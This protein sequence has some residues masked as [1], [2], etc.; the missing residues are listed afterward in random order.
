MGAAVI[1]APQ[2]RKGRE[3]QH[4]STFQDGPNR[5]NR[6]NEMIPANKQQNNARRRSGLVLALVGLL[7]VTGL[8]KG[9]TTPASAQAEARSW[10]YT[11]SLNIARFGH[12][13]TRLPDGKVLVVGGLN[14]IGAPGS[15]EL[16]DPIT[17]LWSFTGNLNVPR[18][19]HTATLLED[20]KVLV[21]GGAY[22]GA[23]TAEVYDPVTGLWSLTGNLNAVRYSHTATRL[24]DGKVLIAGGGDT[25][26]LGPTNAAEVYDPATRTWSLTGNL[27]E[28]R[29]VHTAT[30]LANGEVLVAGGINDF[31][32][33]F[34]LNSAEL[35]D[36]ATKTWRYT[37]SLNTG[38]ADYA[39]VLLLNGD[40]LAAGGDYYSQNNSSEI[41]HV[42]KGTWSN[43]AGGFSLRFYPTLTLLQNGKALITGGA[44]FG[45]YGFFGLPGSTFS[46]AHL[47]NP[48]TGSWKQTAKL[49]EPRAL[50]TATLLSDGKVLVV[51][52]SHAELYDPEILDPAPKIISASV[53]GIKLF[54]T[55]EN[56]DDGAVILLNGE[57]QKTKQPAANPQT[58]LIGKKAGKNI[59][60]GDRVQVRNPDGTLSAEFIFTGS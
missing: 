33:Q 24:R 35:Y 40:V 57:E 15:A 19:E 47:Y 39:A 37:G 58:S 41:Y 50:H 38:R 52:G 29:L 30:L 44:I 34:L 32:G 17:G 56:F 46:D 54:I 28:G 10:S 18:F 12:T 4:G 45:R 31:E 3:K 1:L 16:Y 11:G 55:G 42:A 20:G 53:S 43:N 48:A 36:P 23:I 6:R 60:P 5:E 49:N 7:S 21:A 13:A 9:P 27:N 22:G 59:K 8:V 26:F 14:V 2:D 25:L 51:G